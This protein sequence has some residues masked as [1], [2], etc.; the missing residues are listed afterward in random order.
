[1]TSKKFL[2]LLMAALMI[3]SVSF[4]ALA[5]DVTVT[6]FD[7]EATYTYNTAVTGLSSNWN[8]HDYED[9]TSSD[10]MS[11][12]VDS[13]YTMAFNDE[14]HP[15]D[16]PDRVP[17]D[18]YVWL[19]SMASG[20]P[21]DV[22]EEVKA[23]HPDW[24]PEDATSGYAWAFPLRENLYFDTG[25]HITAET[26][27]EGA[28][29]I[30][31]YKLQNYRS[32][33]VYANTYGIVGAEAFFLQGQTNYRDNGIEGNPMDAMVKGEDGAYTLEGLPVVIAVDKA[34]DWTGG[35]TLKDYVENYGEA[36]FGL[37]TWDELVALM[38]ENGVVPCTD[39]NL[40]LLSGVTT[41][42]ANWGETDADLPNYLMIIEQM[43]D[44]VSFEDTVGIYA[45]D[46]Y[47]LVEV[48]KASCADFTLFYNAIQDS[49]LLVEPTVY[50]ACI[51]QQADGTYVSTYMTS[52][53]T[54][55]S[56]GPYSL[57][58]YQTDKLMHFTRND[59]WYG[60]T[61]DTT[62]IYKDPVD[63]NVYRM[64]ETTDVVMQVVSEAATRLNMFLAGDLM[65]Y[66]LQTA[67]LGQYRNSERTYVTPG[68]TIFFF[69]LTGNEA[70]LNARE[71]AGDFDTATQDIQTILTPSFRKAMAI[72]FDRQAYCDEA[73]PA[74]TPGYG[75]FGKTII[76]DP[77]TAGYY[78]ETEQAKQALCDFY[79]VDVSQFAS[80]DEAVDSITGYD[81]VQAKAYLTAAFQE[82][83]DAGYITDEDGDGKSDQTITML[84]ALSA[85]SDTMTLRINWIDNALEE[86]A[87]DTPFE[88][89]LHI[90]GTAPLGAGSEFAD[91]IKSGAADMV[92]AG[93]SGSAMDPYN[94]LQAYTWDSYSYAAEWYRPAEDM[95]TLTLNDE[96]ITMS[97]YDWAECVTGN[98]VTV[99]DKTYNFGTNSAD[100]ETRVQILA[101]VEGKLLQTYTYIPFANDGGLSMLSYQVDYV[102]DE[103]NPVMGRGGISY[104]KYNYSDAEWA[105]FCNDLGGELPY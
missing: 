41:T 69:L 11:Y 53:E 31:D 60:Y 100:Q 57:A 14:L 95:M 46:E 34:L 35:S 67:D 72:S 89:K 103:Y 61:D 74:T 36:Y 102:V 79:S 81:P 65:T 76:Y 2:A 22:T 15:M 62:Y 26:F 58:E 45:K 85:A 28:K 71:E 88:G 104:M 94:L 86:I 92:L 90:E 43:P 27:V 78:R 5:E 42:N 82:A 64:Y 23:A 55:P 66:G 19:P 8:P 96:E 33:D 59:S 47:T 1:M 83:L 10:Q 20:M 68:A 25:Y 84:Y 9:N 70:G 37:E 49:L 87:K 73:S 50:D 51:S 21:V 44:G 93:W 7:K 77:A 80:L 75:I 40:A 29:R 4:T 16:D 98:N 97:V 13:L 17:Y 91:A 12:L 101:A 63:G 3:F 32:T 18:G 56:Y 24:I 30:L 52:A 38:D 6:E 54:S 99:G 39:E 48:F 105:A